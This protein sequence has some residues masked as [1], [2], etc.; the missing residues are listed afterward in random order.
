MPPADA[1]ALWKNRWLSFGTSAA[2]AA[3][4]T[5]AGVLRTKWLAL[6]LEPAGIGVIGQIAAG[7]TWLGVAAGLGV[8]FPLTRAVGAARGAGDVEGQ[9]RAVWTAIGLVGIATAVVVLLGLLTAE[10]FSTLLLGTPDYATLIRVSML[11]VAGYAWFATIQGWFAGRSDVRAPFTLALAGGITAVVATFFM[12]PRFGLLGGVLGAA[13]FYPAGLAAALL[14]HRRDYGDL[15]GTPPRPMVDRDRVRVLLAV[16]AGSLALA[17]CDQGAML[18][19]RVYYVREH[20][21]AANGHFQAAIAL[22][23]QTGSAFYTYL[24]AYAFGTVS[25][26]G[27]AAGMRAYTRKV[28]LPIILLA[29]AGCATVSVISSPLLRLLYSDEFVP[30]SRLVGWLMLGELSRVAMQTWALASLPLGGVRLWL[31]ILLASP[32]TLIASYPLWVA[33]GAGVESLPLAYASAGLASLATAGVAMSRRG[34]TLAARHVT[35]IVLSLAALVAIAVWRS[36]S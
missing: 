11:S 10:P 36:R 23:Q 27:D 34:V 24:A 9:R 30:A 33:A 17:L 32:V 5:L 22:S 6:H 21:L 16:G 19:A 26:L 13:L 35:A 25:G 2:T 18:F 8:A 28:W 31:P 15:L 4:I 12:V 20:G 7:Q 3:T 29:T 1:V 14:I